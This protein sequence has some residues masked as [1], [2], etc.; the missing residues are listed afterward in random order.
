MQK[1]KPKNRNTSVIVSPTEMNPRSP[2]TIGHSY[3]LSQ[4]DDYAYVHE[5]P[6]PVHVSYRG[7]TVEPLNNG[8]SDK[9]PTFL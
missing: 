8:L 6:S 5:D 7:Y 1:Y 9:K 2:Y 4:P 3:S